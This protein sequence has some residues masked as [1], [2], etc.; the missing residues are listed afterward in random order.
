MNEKPRKNLEQAWPFHKACIDA[1]V[2]FA[3][4][5]V[6]A[7]SFRPKRW[8]KAA[9]ADRLEGFFRAAARK[10]AEL[11]VAPE[12][13]LEGYVISDVTWNR[14]RVDAFLDLAEPIDGPYIARFRK[15]ARELGVCLCFGFAERVGRDSFNSAVFIDDTGRVC[16]T[17][18]KVTETTHRTWNFARQGT[19]VR[20]FDTPWGRAGML[21]C[22][23]RWMPLLART[24]VLDG[25]RF[26]LIPT[27][28]ST[29][30]GQ[31]KAVL[32]RSREN[33]V[34]IV[35]ANVGMVQVISKGEI[36]THQR[37]MNRITYGHIDIPVLPSPEAVRACDKEFASIQPVFQRDQYRAAVKAMKK[38]RPSKDVRRAF[39]PDRQFEALKASEW[40]AKRK[41][42]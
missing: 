14:E 15:L 21:I 8:D 5:R 3:R 16:G 42:R 40:G 28:G 38:G 13:A 11:I 41:A 18:R 36:V 17:Y 22:S 29:E 24:L 33:G 6:A 31:T 37:G 1:S 20:A 30:H 32:A 35:Q 9:N 27:Y 4:R 2:M 12:G 10:G 34:P 7:V 39:T 19:R 25:A 26:L 23:D